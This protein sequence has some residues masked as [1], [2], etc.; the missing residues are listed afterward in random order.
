MEKGREKGKEYTEKR[1]GEGVRGEE[2][3]GMT[4]A[5]EGSAEKKRGKEKMHAKRRENRG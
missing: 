4:Q 1:R 3:K 2:I 5:S